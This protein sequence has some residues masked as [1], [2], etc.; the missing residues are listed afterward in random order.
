MVYEALG[1]LSSK[2]Y[3]PL[4]IVRLFSLLTQSIFFFNH[5][6]TGKSKTL[7]ITFAF[8]LSRSIII[9][10]VSKTSIVAQL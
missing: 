5:L 8:A 6:L 1:F 10:K 2:H 4:V 9:I 7:S 3:W